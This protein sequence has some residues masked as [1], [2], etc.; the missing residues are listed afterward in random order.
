[1]ERKLFISA[2]HRSDGTVDTGANAVD[3][4]KEGRL[5]EELRKLIINKFKTKGVLPYTDGS[6]TSVSETVKII[7]AKLHSNDIAI[8]LHFN[9]F[10]N[11]SVSGT[12]VLVPFKAS[13]FELDLA[14]RLSKKISE[15]LNIRNR[16][17]KTEATSAHGRLL[18]MRAN[19]ENVLI[20]VC[21][22]SCFKDLNS[23]YDNKD[24][25]ADVIV[26][27]LFNSINIL[28]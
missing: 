4:A 8:D 11:P 7:N 5:T 27:E 6:N 20:E 25:V 14:A 13:S 3:N 15:V 28:N 16:G 9:W 1:M 19:C 2:G 26:N 21:F 24:K 17:V 22:I 12:E 10:S 23:Y 18:F